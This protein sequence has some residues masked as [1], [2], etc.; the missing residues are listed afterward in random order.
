[1]KEPKAWHELIYESGSMQAKATAEVQKRHKAL[2]KQEKNAPVVNRHYT[3]NQKRGT[4]MKNKSKRLYCMLLCCLLAASALSLT[5]VAAAED[6]AA[7]A[8]LSLNSLVTLPYV[9]TNRP[10]MTPPEITITWED[11]TYTVELPKGIKCESAEVFG[12]EMTQKGQ[13]FTI[14]SLEAIGIDQKAAE[15][16]RLVI[17]RKLKADKAIA[18]N[19]KNA[20]LF[21][22]YSASTGKPIYVLCY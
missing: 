15:T 8:A 22:S 21:Y 2:P 4:G 13:K 5:G 16:E 14:K 1:M 20:Y 10:D 11:D 6:V 9:S 12:T 7:T 17:Y 19:I 3:K 18:K